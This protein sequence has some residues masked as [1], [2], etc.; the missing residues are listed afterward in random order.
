M[1]CV[2]CCVFFPTLIYF[3][4]CLLFLAGMGL[5]EDE[6]EAVRLQFL[7]EMEILSYLRH[8]NLLLFI[9]VSYDPATRMPLWIITELMSHSLYGIIHDL[10]IELT[11]AEVIDVTAAA[12]EQQLYLACA[13]PRSQLLQGANSNSTHMRRD[14]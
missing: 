13:S 11:F 2:M 7:Q 3:S 10:R 1:R 5:H 4:S 6:L 9:G 14:C 8:P 12:T